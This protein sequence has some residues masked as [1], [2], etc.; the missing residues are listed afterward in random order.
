MAYLT[1]TKII[2][3][4]KNDFEDFVLNS[5]VL[6]Y[7]TDAYTKS[8]L[9]YRISLFKTVLF[10]ILKKR[11]DILKNNIL[12]DV[13]VIKDTL[14][15]YNNF[16]NEINLNLLN[17]HFN[18]F[19]LEST[20]P[21]VMIV[22]TKKNPFKD[23]LNSIQTPQKLLFESEYEEYKPLT[24]LPVFIICHKTKTRKELSINVMSNIKT[25]QNNNKLQD[26]TESVNIKNPFILKE[27]ESLIVYDLEPMLKEIVIDV[28]NNNN[29][30]EVLSDLYYGFFGSITL[31]KEG[32]D[33]VNDVLDMIYYLD[34]IYNPYIKLYYS[35]FQY[36]KE[37][38][39]FLYKNINDLS[40]NNYNNVFKAQHYAFNKINVQQHLKLPLLVLKENGSETKINLLLYKHFKAN[41]V[42][43]QLLLN[44]I[45]EK[46]EVVIVFEY[47]S[48]QYKKYLNAKTILYNDI[49]LGDKIIF[50]NNNCL[51][52]KYILYD[53][54][55]IK[56]NIIF[57]ELAN[58]FILSN[59]EVLWSK[60]DKKNNNGI[61]LLFRIN[62][63]HIPWN[64]VIDYIISNGGFE[65]YNTTETIFQLIVDFNKHDPILGKI[66]INTLLQRSLS[67][68]FKDV[69]PEY[70]N[71]EYNRNPYNVTIETFQKFYETNYI[72]NSN[73]QLE[74]IKKSDLENLYE[75]FLFVFKI[76]LMFINHY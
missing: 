12:I 24:G 55:N 76:I 15:L 48:Q 11:A 64:K 47:K 62:T 37:T 35:L 18:I 67:L 65:K 28:A 19:N 34:K 75:D 56:N 25:T 6:D 49:K 66:I 36:K 27:I 32:I 73:C 53:F 40:L 31:N 26:I 60:N 16:V 52:P 51:F 68:I 38:N 71:D 5:T 54:K 74:A 72:I 33:D 17:L 61:Y 8:H 3:Q 41:I 59:N 2:K 50:F 14:V 10:L 57:N 7:K 30:D 20:K 44:E 4:I 42:Q 29:V 58:N 43:D 21:N 9:E 63:T 23:L 13:S 46:K 45:N 69:Y 70:D 1:K 39:H 22:E